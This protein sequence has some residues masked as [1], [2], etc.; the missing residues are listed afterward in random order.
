M[1]TVEQPHQ[2]VVVSKEA[3]LYGN[4]LDAKTL[5]ITINWRMPLGIFSMGHVL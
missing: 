1:A 4:A 3:L 5:I 2:N